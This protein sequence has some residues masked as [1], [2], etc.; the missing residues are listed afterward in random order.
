MSL[1]CDER[2]P[3]CLR[4]E[5]AR[6][7]C[8]GYR[9]E[10]E[11]VHRNENRSLERR[12]RGGTSDKG[13]PAVRVN[14]ESGVWLHS[15]HGNWQLTPPPESSGP[16]PP[17]RDQS[18]SPSLSVSI[19]EQASCHFAANFILVPLTSHRNGHLD[20]VLPLIAKEPP[21]SPLRHAFRACAYAAFGG[22]R[23]TNGIDLPGMARKE[24]AEALNT[25]HLWLGNPSVAKSDSLVASVL[26]LILFEVSHGCPLPTLSIPCRF[27][28]GEN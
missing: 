27:I 24:Y 17:P 8:T 12:I 23:K 1:Q 11:I 26:L 7:T 21:N 3:T 5:K 9:P 22:A 19:D 14:T 28:I 20:F 6:R 10:F 13:Q 2:K 15:E 18:L 4:C 25:T 16:S